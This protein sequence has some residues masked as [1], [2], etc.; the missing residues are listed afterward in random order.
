MVDDFSGLTCKND[1]PASEPT[2][3]GPQ[4]P[5]NWKFLKAT[6]FIMVKA[7][8]A[9]TTTFDWNLNQSNK[10]NGSSEFLASGIL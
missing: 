2:W 9:Q 7:E 3:S 8:D 4:R 1:T 10:N 6:T 5:Y